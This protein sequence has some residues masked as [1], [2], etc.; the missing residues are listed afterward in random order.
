M[1]L[2]THPQAERVKTVE[3]LLAWVGQHQREHLATWRME[4]VDLA[5]EAELM[6]E[7]GVA[8]S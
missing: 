5:L 8:L 4:A 1:S 3:G 6:A 7:M 2:A